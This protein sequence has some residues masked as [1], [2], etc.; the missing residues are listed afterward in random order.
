MTK[1]SIGERIIFSINWVNCIHIYENQINLKFYLTRHTRINVGGL[2]IS[3]Y[4]VKQ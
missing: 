2:Q 1:Q 3:M 4:K